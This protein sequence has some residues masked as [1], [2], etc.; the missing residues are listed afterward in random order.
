[1]SEQQNNNTDPMLKF[2]SCKLGENKKGNLYM[3]LNLSPEEVDVLLEQADKSCN[4]R[5]LQIQVHTSERESKDGRKFLGAVGF[6]RGIPEP[7]AVESAPS[8]R[9]SRPGSSKPAPAEGSGGFGRLAA[10]RRGRS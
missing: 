8:T 4:E 7:R 3:T 1:M 6:I 2:K 9:S 5:G 10:L